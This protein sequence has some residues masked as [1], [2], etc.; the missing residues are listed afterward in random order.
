[1]HSMGFENQNTVFTPET[2]AADKALIANKLQTARDIAIDTY[3]TSVA[4]TASIFYDAV[5]DST[6][7]VTRYAIQPSE[8]FADRMDVLQAPVQTINPG[9]VPA[10]E[11]FVDKLGRA[12]TSEAI[13][14]SVLYPGAKET[15]KLMA[16]HGPTVVWTQ[17]DMYGPS[18]SYLGFENGIPGSFEQMKKVAGAGAG[19]IRREVARLC[20]D[21]SGVPIDMRRKIRDTLTVVA[22]EDKF[23]AASVDKVVAYLTRLGREKAIVIDD[24]VGNIQKMQGLLAERGIETNGIWVRQGR[25]GKKDAP[26]D[27]EAIR[28]V[29]TVDS[30]TADLLPENFATI[31]DFD[32]VFSSQSARTAM[33]RDAV[34]ELLVKNGWIAAENAKA[35]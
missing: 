28:E 30:I 2:I 20:L 33:Q 35:V 19:E 22:S 25:Y 21:V 31:C 6:N 10:K 12:W 13:H 5:F 27:H 3:E 14:T 34:Y 7:V 8:T 24:R 16:E 29:P 23:S 9:N 17:G 1:M 18:G 11:T 15:L 26:Y 4:A 32:G